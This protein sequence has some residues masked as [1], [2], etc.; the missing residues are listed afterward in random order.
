MATPALTKLALRIVAARLGL[1]PRTTDYVVTRDIDVPTRDGEHLRTDLY[2]PTSA[3]AGTLL[4]RTPYGRSGLMATVVAGLFAGRGFRVVMQ[5]ARGTFGSTGPFDPV[6]N[7][8][9]DGADTV[10]WMRVQPWFDGRFATLGS[11][12]LG[13]TQWALLSDPPP[14]LDTSVIAMATHDYGQYSWGTGSFPLADLLTWTYHLVHQEDDGALRSLVRSFT[15][16]RRMRRPLDTVPLRDAAAQVLGDRAPWFESWVRHQDPADPYWEPTRRDV[17]L[18][19]ATAP[20]LLIAGWQDIFVTRALE[21]YSLLA[22]RGVE[23]ALIIG[24][25]THNDGGGD[26]LRET[27]SWLTG[28]RWSGV[29]IYVRGAAS[30]VSE[31]TGEGTGWRELPAWPPPA[32]DTVLYLQP[33]AALADQPAGDGA[34]AQ[35]V[36]DP[37]DPTPSIGG[38]LLF[39]PNGYREDSALAARADVVSFTG[40]PL[41]DALEVIGTPRIE[42]AHRADTGWADVWVRISEVGTD[43]RSH[44][45]SDGYVRRSPDAEPVLHLDLDPIAHRFAA[46]ARI[47]VMV[48]GGSHPHYLRNHG[49]GEPAWTATRMVPSTHEIGAGSRLLLPVPR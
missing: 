33:G 39:S 23:P 17:A 40:A 5:S 47:R 45:V 34:I 28:P 35:F 27:L 29:R 8:T 48:A 4:I 20:V 14:E 32:D 1:S 19:R 9:D 26:V 25:W 30:G 6:R 13:F 21:E 12:Y 22:T 3:S 49:T 7:E 24:P 42:L 36:F 11:S 44:N 2:T 31:A 41:A 37:A 10:A 43:G 38:R 46:G 18:H 16:A 15:T